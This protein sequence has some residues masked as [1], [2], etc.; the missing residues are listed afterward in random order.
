MSLEVYQV[1][2]SDEFCLKR[3]PQERLRWKTSKWVTTGAMTCDLNGSI[4]A[5]LSLVYFGSSYNPICTAKCT[6]YLRV[7]GFDTS[8]H[9]SSLSSL[10]NLFRKTKSALFE[11]SL[12]GFIRK[13]RE[14]WTLIVIA[15]PRKRLSFG[16]LHFKEVLE[17]VLYKK[18][19][20]TENNQSR[21]FVSSIKTNFLNHG[22]SRSCVIIDHKLNEEANIRSLNW[23]T[24][25]GF[26]SDFNSLSE[27]SHSFI[28]GHSIKN[29]YNQS[30]LQS[31]IHP[32]WCLHSSTF[33][34]F[35]S[36]LP[37]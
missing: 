6:E 2:V 33:L 19:P 7:E 25:Y 36:F 13:Y 12:A 34:Q 15:H 18:I 23:R 29:I 37:K 10:Q 28:T 1:N 24:I 30:N 3:L 9:F 26:I 14:T 17:P 11:E 8:P 5:S 27:Y 4:L 20:D 22:N 32:L 31:P 21:K 16:I 35:Q